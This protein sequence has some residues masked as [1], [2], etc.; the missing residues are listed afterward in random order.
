M[1]C[2]GR[3]SGCK[4]DILKVVEPVFSHF[5]RLNLRNLLILFF[6]LRLPRILMAV[7][8]GIGFAVSGAA[9]Q[10]NNAQS[11]SKSF[12]IGI[13]SA[14]GFGASLGIVLNMGIIGSADWIVVVNAFLFAVLAAFLVYSIARFRGIHPETLILAGIAIMYFFRPQLPCYNTSPVIVS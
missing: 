13:S 4:C 5:L 7:I 1:V 3:D 14:A 10:G 8:G 11:L 12:T 9:M 6:A 2:C